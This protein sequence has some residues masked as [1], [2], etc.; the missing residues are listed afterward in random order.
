MPRKTPKIVISR[1]DKVTLLNR[2][3][4]RTL[5]KQTVDRAKMILDSEAGKPV[6]QIAQ[7]LNTYPNKVIYW[8]QGYV[9]NGLEGLHDNPRSG[10]PSIY[11][12]AFRNSVLKVLS[13]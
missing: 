1:E 2:A 10:R 9:K 5:P 8:R 4:S 3:S 6:K 12:K 11:G 13:K 7:E